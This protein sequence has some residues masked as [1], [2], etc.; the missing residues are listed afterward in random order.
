MG[1]TKNCFLKR[2]AIFKCAQ[3]FNNDVSDQKMMTTYSKQ[4]TTIHFIQVYSIK[5]KIKCDW[6]TGFWGGTVFWVLVM[7]IC[8][9][10]R[11][12]LTAH[13]RLRLHYPS[14][15]LVVFVH[16]CSSWNTK[17]ATG[18]YKHAEEN[19]KVVARCQV[20]SIEMCSI[21]TLQSVQHQVVPIVTVLPRSTGKSMFGN[22]SH[23]S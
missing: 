9:F 17:F 1:Q 10:C 18:L 23:T 21:S 4:L 6:L 13:P 15:R 20:F 22:L 2:R 19:S 16:F 7:G 5:D 3:K 11:I 8:M 12:H 14:P